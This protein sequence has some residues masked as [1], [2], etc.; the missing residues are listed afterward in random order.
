MAIFHGNAIPSAVLGDQVIAPSSNDWDYSFDGGGDWPVAGN[1]L[2]DHE[3]GAYIDN[4]G[5]DSALSSLI[6]FDGDFDIEFTATG[7]DNSAFGIHEIAEDSKRATDQR[8]M[9]QASTESWHYI[10]ASSGAGTESHYYGNTL[11]DG[12]TYAAG[13]VIKIERRSGVI[14]FYDDGVIAHAYSQTST[15]PVRFITSAGGTPFNQ[16]FDNIKFTDSDKVQRDGFLNE[17]QVDQS[18]F[19]DVVTNGKS[20]GTEFMATRS[21]YIETITMDLRTVTT[22]F[23]AK[24]ELW[25]S[26]RTT[27]VAKIGTESDTI[28]L[29]STGQKTFTFSSTDAVVEKGKW[30]WWVTTDTSGGTGIVNPQHLADSYKQGAGTGRHDII[31]SISGS[32]SASVDTDRSAEIKINTSAGEPTPDHDTL[33]LI[34]S[35]TTDGST[36][37]TDSSQFAREDTPNGQ[38]QHDTATYQSGFGASSIL[39]DGS[40]DFLEYTSNSVFGF[41]SDFTIDF[42][43]RL[44][45]TGIR[46]GLISN[47][48]NDSLTNNIGFFFDLGADNIIVVQLCDGANIVLKATTALVVT[49]WYHVALV[50]SR[51]TVNLYLNGSSEDSGT[52]TGTINNPSSLKIGRIKDGS[53]DL[54]GWMDEV[55]ISRVA[56]W[57]A[58]FTPP[59]APYS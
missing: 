41:P 22:S 26:N 45:S 27:P 40:G 53:V 28:A 19:G 15:N 9:Y 17:G 55:R 1:S 25:S 14:T 52:K 43:V 12:H 59:T 33:L 54:T 7:V 34:H 47:S 50:R 3:D 30:Y 18:G 8:P 6:T 24:C 49:T 16:D 23:N 39:F 36:T 51:S 20:Q 42:W 56:R 4:V 35:D 58:N 13:S 29:D 10:E 31:A 57:D 38:V 37:F 21:G 44:S 32:S 5:G 2:G 46:H 48:V 11:V